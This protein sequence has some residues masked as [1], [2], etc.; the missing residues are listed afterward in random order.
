[1]KSRTLLFC[2]A[3]VGCVLAGCSSPAARIRE[4][5][6]LFARLGTAQQDLIRQGKVGIGFDEDMVRLAVGEPDRKWVR[7]EATGTSEVWSY[8]AWERASGPP[9]PGGYYGYYEPSAYYLNAFSRSE[10]EFFKVVFKDGK[11]TS[12]EQETP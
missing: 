2:F 1:M 12:V 5:H 4:N 10:R 3:I 8:T 11:V 7:T 9:Y 6:A